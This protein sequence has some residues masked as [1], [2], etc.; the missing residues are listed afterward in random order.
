MYTFNG[1]LVIGDITGLWKLNW[2]GLGASYIKADTF[3]GFSWG[4]DARLVF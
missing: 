3:S 4:I 2:I 1:R